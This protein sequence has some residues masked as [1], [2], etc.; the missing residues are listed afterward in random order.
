MKLLRYIWALPNTFLGLIFVP[1]ALL[2]RGRMEIVNGVL[3]IHGGFVSWFLKNCLPVRGYL[4]ALTLGHVV[5]GYNKKLLS[6]YRS[7]EHAHVR[8]YEILGPMFLPVYL[9]AAIWAWLRGR[10]A[11]RGNYLER[12]ARE[13][14]HEKI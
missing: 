9:A 3:E 4:G 10:G 12:K 5:L 8:Q 6:T 1:F 14:S 11:Y 7:H 2:T 13:H